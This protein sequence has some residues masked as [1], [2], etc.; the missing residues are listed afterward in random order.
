MRFFWLVSVLMS[1]CSSAGYLVE[2]GLGQWRLF[3]H[4]RPV[5]EVLSSPNTSDTVRHGIQ[6]VRKAKA[7][8]VKDLGLRA[9]K[10]YE[11]FVQLD[12]PCV[13]WAVSASHP[14]RLE[15]KKWKFPIVGEVPY[16]GYF[17]K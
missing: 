13:S 8:A 10:N 6:M 12:G 17:T 2:T 14:I 3:N 1:G 15:E 11:T 16:L 7:F 4:A 9:T 5:D